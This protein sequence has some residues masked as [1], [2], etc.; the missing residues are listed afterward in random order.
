MTIKNTA[1]TLGAA[2]ILAGAPALASAATTVSAPSPVRLDNVQ[3]AQYYGQ[4]NDYFPG[5][6]T[7]SFTNEAAKPV[8]DVVFD[9]EANGQVLRQYDDAGNYAQ[10]STVR[11]SFYDTEVGS[12]QTLAVESV[13]FA[14]GTVWNNT[15]TLPSRRQSQAAN[16]HTADT[17]SLPEYN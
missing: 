9:L 6:V 12:G 7:V 10:G 15:D 13:T 16:V 5:L 1:A 14:D 2:L 3:I 4:F 8:T 17:T 11:H